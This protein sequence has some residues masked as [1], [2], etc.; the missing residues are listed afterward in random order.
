MRIFQL[1]LHFQSGNSNYEFTLK[2]PITS[3]LDGH[4]QIIHVKKQK[5]RHIKHESD[6]IEV[7]D[8]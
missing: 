2:L 4:R 3:E 8:W 1:I 7:N 6:A 5:S